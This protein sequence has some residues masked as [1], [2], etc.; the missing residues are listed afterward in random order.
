MYAWGCYSTDSEQL[1]KFTP[2]EVPFLSGLKLKKLCCGQ[3]FTVALCEDKDNAER[4]VL[5]AGKFKPFSRQDDYKT[6]Q[7]Q[8]GDEVHDSIFIDKQTVYL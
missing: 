8:K 7:L 1:Q 2:Y 6:M 4:D 3:N 5:I